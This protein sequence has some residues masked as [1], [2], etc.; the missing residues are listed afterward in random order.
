MTVHK[1]KNIVGALLFLLLTVCILFLSPIT[2]HAVTLD[3]DGSEKENPYGD[4]GL[5]K[6]FEAEYYDCYMPYGLTLKEIGGYAT[7]AIWAAYQQYNAPMAE[8]MQNAHVGT[9]VNYENDLLGRNST[10]SR[11]FSGMNAYKESDTGM[12]IVED[13]NG[14][15]YYISAFPGFMFYNS[16]A[17]TNGFPSYSSEAWGTAVDIILTDGTVIHFAMGDSVAPQ[18]SNGGIENPQYFDVIYE[19]APLTMPQYKHLYQAQSGHS[20]EVWGTSGC[21]Q[22]FMDKYNIGDGE[23]QN[24][25]AVARIYNK[26]VG[27]NPERASGVSEEVSYSLGDVTIGSGGGEDGD[28]GTGE[29]SMGNVITSEWDLVGMTHLKS[30]LAE[31]QSQIEL[32]SREDL[33]T[34]EQYSVATVKENLEYEHQASAIDTVRVSVV[35]V[36]LCLVFYSVMLLVCY[37]FDKSNSFIEISLV[38]FITF[39]YLE[40]TDDELAKGQQGKA[41]SKRLLVLVVIIMIIGCL[42]ISGGVLQA[43][44]QVMINIHD[45]FLS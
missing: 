12:Q 41:S 30:K 24:K 13:S 42:F 4:T 37:L 20:V 9:F 21:S 35:F 8:S 25:I 11:A 19:N 23:D 6:S 43:V 28:D 22:A 39:G 26:K 31:Q 5:A 27:D 18:H 15:Q 45:K 40:Y 17:G 44:M 2:A 16:T 34:G 29:D 36:G 33:S 14:T 38:K 1:T 7:G 32:K 3:N 10:L